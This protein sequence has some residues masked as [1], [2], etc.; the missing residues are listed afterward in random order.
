M[1]QR[2]VVV[3]VLLLGRALILGLVRRL[4]SEEQSVE[5]VGAL[6]LGGQELVLQ[7]G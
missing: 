7:L 3:V 4:E 1:N 2:W 6:P 5:R